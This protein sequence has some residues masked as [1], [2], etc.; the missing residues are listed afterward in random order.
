MKKQLE[1][2]QLRSRGTYTI[3]IQ[4]GSHRTPTGAISDAHSPTIFCLFSFDLY[5][6]FNKV[7]YISNK[8]L[9]IYKCSREHQ[10]K[11]ILHQRLT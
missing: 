10:E 5:V 6:C 2:K 8:A 11:V 4:K 7:F 3:N 1:V 9:N